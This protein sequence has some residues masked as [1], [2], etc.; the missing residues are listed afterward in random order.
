MTPGGWQRM[1]D[2][3]QLAG[4]RRSAR[5]SPASCRGRRR[6]ATA[7]RTATT[8]TAR[9]ACAR[10]TG[11]SA[12]SPSAWRRPRWWTPATREETDQV[13]FGATVTYANTGG[14]ENTI[15]I[16]GI[17]ETDL[18]QGCVSWIS[19]IARALIKARE[20]D[21]V[22]LRTPGGVEDLEILEVRYE[23]IP[24]EPFT[25]PENGWTPNAK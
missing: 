2:E 18:P 15:R 19:P 17:D 14:G 5:R 3:L 1:R 10:S 13:F 20:G 25:A 21:T 9:S 7:R 23:D 8:S 6:T 16:V 24:M 4:E 22:T 11:A 12:T